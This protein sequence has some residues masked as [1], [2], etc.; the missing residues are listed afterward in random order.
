MG[1]RCVKSDENKKI[2]YVDANNFCGHSMCQPLPYDKIKLD[3]NFKLE[4]I[5]KTNVDSDIGYFVEVGLSYPD[6]I[7]TKTKNFPF[8][9]EN[10]YINPDDFSDYMRTIKPDAFTQT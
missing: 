4:D 6:N 2:S 7:K 3:K 9:P 5:S 1:D 8:A 10:K